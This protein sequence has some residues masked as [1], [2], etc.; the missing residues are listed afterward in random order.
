MRPDSLF[1]LFAD[2]TTLKGVGARVKAALE[3]AMGPRI[4]DLV[5]TPPSGLIDR[6]Y[7]PTISGARKDEICT[8]TCLLYTSPSPRD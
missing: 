1:P 2:V 7:R 4:K 8:F 6:S 5:L 3:R